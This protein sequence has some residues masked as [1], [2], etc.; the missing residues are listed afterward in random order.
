MSAPDVRLELV[1]RFARNRET[2]RQPLY[3][4]AQLR[5]EFMDLFFEAL[6]SS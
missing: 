2:Y 4:E 6:G 5:Q 1:E 3:K